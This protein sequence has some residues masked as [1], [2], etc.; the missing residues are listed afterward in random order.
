M[1]RKAAATFYHQRSLNTIL[2]T[3]RTSDWSGELIQNILEGNTSF[4]N[5]E[6][7]TKGHESKLLSIKVN[8]EVPVTC[9]KIQKIH[10]GEELR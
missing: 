6:G 2:H 7:F 1:K 8:V 9:V 3:S 5:Q 10:S 4:F